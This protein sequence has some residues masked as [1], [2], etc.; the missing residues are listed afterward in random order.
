MRLERNAIRVVGKA[1]WLCLI[2]ASGYR[3]RREDA[4]FY[5][6]GNL[7][8]SYYLPTRFLL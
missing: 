2:G 1:L 6:L 7:V 3:A 4:R 5:S 8:R